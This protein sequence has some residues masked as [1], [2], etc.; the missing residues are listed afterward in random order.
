MAANT[1]IKGIE[2]FD[3]DIYRSSNQDLQALGMSDEELRTH[4]TEAG[5]REQRVFGRTETATEY[6]SMRHLR[7]SGL[8]IGAG[9]H[10]TPI[11]GDARVDYADVEDGALFGGG[12][13]HFRYSLD[14]DPPETLLGHYDFLIASHV[15][16]HA[17]SV[18]RS[19]RNACRIIK[20]SGLA[21]L[22]VP[23]MECLDDS[24]WMPRFDLEHHL[25]EFRDSTVFAQMHDDLA[26][27]RMIDEQ[28]AML[29]EAGS[30]DAMVY[31]QIDLQTFMREFATEQDRKRLR[32]MT[33]KHT[34]TFD[35]WMELMVDLKRVLDEQFAIRDCQYGLHRRDCHFVLRRVP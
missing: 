5:Y 35:G 26:F 25:A 17:D 16:E 30:G 11:F 12:D 7:G 8:E 29:R 2:R 28:M 18:I 34:Y 24:R 23:D 15:L 31:G 10:P 9:R 21:Y 14:D 13:V 33:H 4:F 3:A 32:F 6:L 1:A 27:P 20:P 22:V 19:V